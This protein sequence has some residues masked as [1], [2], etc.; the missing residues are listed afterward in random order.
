[1][2]GHDQQSECSFLAGFESRFNFLGRDD[3]FPLTG[4]SVF[5]G[6]LAEW[7]LSIYGARQD[8]RSERGN[9]DQLRE[10]FAVCFEFDFDLRYGRKIC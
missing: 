5:V 3:V 8:T 6:I 4:E 2:L 10:Y 1:M 7:S 9:S